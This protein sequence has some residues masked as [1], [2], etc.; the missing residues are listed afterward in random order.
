MRNDFVNMHSEFHSDM[1]KKL[2]YIF[3][4][5]DF[6]YAKIFAK[7]WITWCVIKNKKNVQIS[8]DGLYE[9]I[10]P[11]PAGIG[12]NLFTPVYTVLHSK[13][14]FCQCLST[15]YIFDL[16]MNNEYIYTYICKL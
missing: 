7:F 8:F 11:L 5:S 13:G 16:W 14:I 9:I 2:W 10:A 4:E 1:S 6:T 12:I 3:L 15:M